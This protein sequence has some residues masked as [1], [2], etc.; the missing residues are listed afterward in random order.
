MCMCN[1]RN[2]SLIPIKNDPAVN[3]KALKGVRV[4]KLRDASDDG[5]DGG[6][7]DPPGLVNLAINGIINVVG[8]TKM[9]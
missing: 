6:W 3:E 1:G 7:V 8:P 9:N 4:D 2:E 5:Y